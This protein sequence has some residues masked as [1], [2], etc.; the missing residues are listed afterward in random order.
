[1]REERL[2]PFYLPLSEGGEALVLRLDVL[3]RWERAT[4]ARFKSEAPWIRAKLYEGLLSR[5]K[6]DPSVSD[7][8]DRLEE[9]IER[10]LRRLLGDKDVRIVLERIRAI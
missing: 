1:L 9:E 5:F 10:S 4:A 6:G 3:V 7:R 2:D 8:P